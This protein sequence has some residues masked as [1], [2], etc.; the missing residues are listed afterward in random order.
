[1][2]GSLRDSEWYQ[3]YFKRLRMEHP[4][5]KIAILHVTAPREAVFQRALERG[6]QTGRIVPRETLEMA[7]EQVPRS[8]EILKPLADYFCELNNAPGATDIELIT[9]GE[10]WESFQSQ[11][12]QTC[13]WVPSKLR[14]RPKANLTPR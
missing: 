2:D 8:V 12:L 1:M 13:A 9:N 4:A 14:T 5:L 3:F 7:L 6:V 10:T 11:W